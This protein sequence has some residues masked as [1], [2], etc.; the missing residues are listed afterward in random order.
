MSHTFLTKG[1]VITVSIAMFLSPLASVYAQ[2]GAAT[3]TPRENKQ[4]KRQNIKE[5]VEQKRE[6]IQERV[7]GFRIQLQERRKQLIRL[8]YGRML[9]RFEAAL[10]RQEKLADRISSRLD[11]IEAT[12]RNVGRE[13]TKLGEVRKL[14]TE[15]RAK[16]AEIRIEFEEVLNANDPKAAFQGVREL[17]ANEL[18]ARIKKI[19]S[20]LVEVITSLRGVG[21]RTA[22]S[23]P[24]T[25][26]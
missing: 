5:Q 3:T 2:P 11:K 24:S 19:H 15:S 13:R 4:E 14:I 6:N 10:D 9:G 22:T 12:D 23:T 8:F 17:V 18:L 1:A 25:L 26:P 20:L 16:V 7:S 21:E